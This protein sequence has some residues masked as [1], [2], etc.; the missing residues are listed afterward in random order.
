MS[1][2][3]VT[4]IPFLY[5]PESGLYSLNK[6]ISR[7]AIIQSAKSLLAQQVQITDHLLKQP[8]LLLDFVLTRLGHYEREVVSVLFL[9]AEHQLLSYDELFFGAF[10]RVQVYPELLIARAIGYQASAVVIAHNHPNTL[11]AVFSTD[12]IELIQQLRRILAIVN[13]VL[14]DYLLVSPC[15]GRSLRQ[16][17]S[18]LFES[19][20]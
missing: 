12:D 17:Q 11:E 20:Q 4:P 8:Q 10:N 7:E 2:S 18:W 9:N 1:E 15:E 14:H 13:I 3:I 5:Q 16:A 19:A 6:P